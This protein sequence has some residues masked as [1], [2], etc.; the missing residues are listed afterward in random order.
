M[1][2]EQ[3]KHDDRLDLLRVVSILAVIGIHTFGVQNDFA[4]IISNALCRFS[5][6]VFAMM[7]GF[8]SMRKIPS[9]GDFYRRRLL[10]VGIPLLAFSALYSIQAIIAGDTFQNVAMA[11]LLGKPSY[12]LWFGFMI[13][14]VY[15][16]MPLLVRLVEELPHYLLLTVAVFLV[17]MTRYVGSGFWSILPFCA[18]ALIGMIIYTR[19]KGGHS[20]CL[21]LGCFAAW[22]AVSYLSARAFISGVIFMHTSL[23]SIAGSCLFLSGMMLLVK[24]SCR[25]YGV[26]AAAKYVY[27]VYLFHV[28]AIRGL[29]HVLPRFFG[30]SADG[31]FAYALTLCVST[32]LIS[33]AVVSCVAKTRIGAWLFG[34]ELRKC[35][36]HS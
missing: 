24:P 35:F 34:V 32:V 36:C 23:Y 4:C 3:M 26:G 5:V 10:R 7:S 31:G 20:I 28:I 2:K 18:Y 21:A 33:F 8:L 16:I 15:V 25:I 29:N 19:I 22:V 27:G 6:P 1:D 12:H 30:N 13:C 11:F 14:G 17:L 9:L